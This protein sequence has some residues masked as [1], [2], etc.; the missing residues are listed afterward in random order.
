MRSKKGALAIT[1]LMGYVWTSWPCDPNCFGATFLLQWDPNLEPDIAGYKIHWGTSSRVY[2]KSVDVGAV[3]SY[4]LSGLDDGVTY[5]FAVTAYNAAGLESDYSN[6][7]SGRKNLPPTATAQ[8]HP[9]SG[10]A[11]LAVNF[12]GQGRDPDGTI[13]FRTWDFGD[14][15]TSSVENPSHVY[16]LPG[17]YNATFTVLDNDGAQATSVIEISVTS[18]PP[19]PPPQNQPPSLVATANPTEGPSPLTVSFSA[20]ATD[21]D[22][23]VTAYFWEFGDGQTSAQ[24]SPIHVYETPGIYI[25][26][27]TATDNQGAY[28][29]KLLTIT[30]S[31]PNTAPTLKATVTPQEGLPPLKVAFAAEAWDP[32]GGPVFV[33]WDFGDGNHS[34]EALTEH[35]YTK[36][37]KYTALVEARDTQG[38]TASMT[39]TIRV[40]S[41]LPPPKGF[42]LLSQ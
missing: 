11:P 19:P 9:T 15:T 2:Q 38:A 12:S 27:V 34:S 33:T 24:Q 37:G 42:K 13:V 41:K 28:D 25:A 14:G 22:G 31:S 10:H 32:E 36:P 8:A 17:I 4:E 20:S 16:T 29:S 6:E 18:L 26:R 7:V 5:Y 30:V 3:T 35:I 21:P 1:F 39:F 40:R 23:S